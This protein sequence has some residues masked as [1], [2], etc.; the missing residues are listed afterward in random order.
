MINKLWIWLFVGAFVMGGAMGQNKAFVDTF[1][2]V[3]W[4]HTALLFIN[5][6]MGYMVV[7]MIAIKKFKVLDYIEIERKQ[8]A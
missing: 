8:T 2:I 5:S 7:F 6:V 4:Y 3:P 1:T